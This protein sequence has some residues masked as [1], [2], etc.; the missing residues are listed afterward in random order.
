MQRERD[1][2]REISR[3]LTELRNLLAPCSTQSVAW[4]CLFYRFSVERGKSPDD[5]LSS[6]AKQIPFLLAVLLSGHQPTDPTPFGQLEWRRARAILERLFR[7]YTALY[8]PSQKEIGQLTPEW[9]RVREV[10]MLAFLSYFNTGLLAQI[11]QIVERIQSY[12]TPFDSELSEAL[13]ISATQALTICDWISGRLQK[14]VDDLHELAQAE[15]SERIMLL[16]SWQ[17]ERWSLEDFR[18]AAMDSPHE[19]ALNRMISGAMSLGLIAFPELHA[20]FPD[21]AEAFWRQF[22]VGRGEAPEIRYPTEQSTYETHPLIRHS[23]TEAI[24]PIMNYLFSGLLLVGERTLQQGSA[25]DSF[26][27]TRDRVL[28][29]ESLEK[30]R[31]FLGPRARIWSGVYETPDAQ[32]EHDIVVADDTFFLLVEAKAAPPLEPFRNPEKAFVRLRRAFA[33]DTGIQKAYAQANRVARKL[34]SGEA[35][36]LY[37]SRG[38]EVGQLS[39]DESKEPFCICVTRDDFGALATDLAL[40][41]EKNGDDPYPWVVNILDLGNLAEAWS[42]LGWGA[43]EFRTYLGQRIQL[44]GKVFSDDELDYAGYF[45]RHG[46]F[47]SVLKLNADLLVLTPDYQDIFDELEA[48][49]RFGA[50][51]PVLEKTEPHVVDVK[52]ALLTPETPAT[53][54]RAAR[55]SNRKIG[56]NDPCPCGSGKKFK[57]CCG[58]SR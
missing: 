49:L 56:R 3:G 34:R 53:N 27:R 32:F 54:V 21:T 23:D 15:R 20:A 52:K 24:C 51:P 55:P 39:P 44:H 37:D 43:T 7:S 18:K 58:S 41:L 19:E 8:A 47:K 25:R 13:G 40:L 31:A 38:R 5:R 22:S 14:S 26:L 1:L 42:Y 46:D 35:V 4:W 29:Q 12:L 11:H 33:A 10:S 17:T 50:P 45:I 30:M 9:H 16:D 48:H 36:Q 28:E 57:K 2:D 6:P